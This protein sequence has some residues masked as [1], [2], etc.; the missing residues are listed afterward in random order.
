[1][2]S[3]SRGMAEKWAERLNEIGLKHNPKSFRK[4]MTLIAWSMETGDIIVVRFAEDRQY[5]DI[6]CISQSK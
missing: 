2:N 6:F 1:M 5:A 4:L 3:I